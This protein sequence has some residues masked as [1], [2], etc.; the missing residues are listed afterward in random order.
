MPLGK[1]GQADG[2]GPARNR[3]S[4]PRARPE[5]PCRSSGSICHP[6]RR[7]RSSRA[8]GG[9]GRQKRSLPPFRTRSCTAVTARADDENSLA[10]WLKIVGLIAAVLLLAAS[11]IYYATRPPTADAL[12]ARI[13][14]AE[15]GGAEQLANVE[16]DLA[17]FL[18]AFPDDPRRR[19]VEQFQEQL[20]LEQL[21]RRFVLRARLGSGGSLSRSSERMWTPSGKRYRSG[22]RV[23]EVPGAPR[24]V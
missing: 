16:P 22:R 13:K 9:T 7:G 15:E 20:D 1:S 24:R 12:Y 3:R 10:A 6:H 5:S 14:T 11:F 23:G 19:E 2:Q 8:G 17:R 18:A 4:S 21:Q